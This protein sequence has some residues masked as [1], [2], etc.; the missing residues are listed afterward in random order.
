MILAKMDPIAIV[1]LGCRFPGA[2]GPEAFWRLLLDGRDA[3]VEVPAN[4]WN[5][6]ALYHDDPVSAPG[7]I[8]N[9]LGG[10]LGDIELFDA[11]FFGISPREAAAMDPQQ[12]MLLETAWEA[13]DDAGL[14][15]DALR[16]EKVGVF[17]GIAAY[18]YAEIQHA[19]DNRSLIGP[20]TNTGLALSIAAN[21]ISYIF[22]L[23]GPSI[24]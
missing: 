16:G 5:R 23:R 6:E 9:R 4:R 13:I 18:D 14:I 24:A 1:G 11:G 15:A 17:V 21:R 22:D 12:R 8:S 19:Y 20:H 7:S 10:F 3:I 2:S